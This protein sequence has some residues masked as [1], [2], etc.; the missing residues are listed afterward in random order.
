MAFSGADADEVAVTTTEQ[1]PF[2]R[3]ASSTETAHDQEAARSSDIIPLSKET[4]HRVG[5]GKSP[6]QVNLHNLSCNYWYLARLQLSVGSEML[7]L[8]QL[9][10]LLHTATV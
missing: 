10:V 1:P 3:V 8:L 5:E 7:A 2:F 9:W 4:F 6:V